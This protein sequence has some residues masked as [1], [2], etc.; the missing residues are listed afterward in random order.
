MRIRDRGGTRG[1]EG[2]GW[3]WMGAI[4]VAGRAGCKTRT[5][6]L[7]NDIYVYNSDATDVTR[8][9]LRYCD[10]KRVDCARRFLRNI[11][12]YNCLS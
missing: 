10:L 8:I 9:F 5:V 3:R 2:W 7:C 12:V 11:V 4:V 1:R 6:W